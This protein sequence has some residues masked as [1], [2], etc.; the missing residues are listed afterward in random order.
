LAISNLRGVA[1]GGLAGAAALALILSGCSS[2]PAP[3]T[4]ATATDAAAG[5][6]KT[7]T[8]PSQF[9]LG[10]FLP[11]TG[12]L[13][14]LGPAAV[15]GSA[16]AIQ[17]INDAGGVNGKPATVISTDSSDASHDADISQPSIDKLLSSNVSAILGAESSSVTLNVLSSKV[18]PAC[19]IMFSPANTADELSGASKWYFRDAVP[20]SVE[21]DALG[22]Q[23]L[24]DGHTKVAILVFS[25]AYGV[26]LRDSIEKAVTDNGGTVTYGAKGSNQEFA[27]TETNFA[28]IVSAALATNPDAIVV[29]AFDQTPAILGALGSA[30]W[31]M[32]NTYFVDGNAADYTGT[33]GVPD[34]TGA[35]TS[36][37]GNIPSDQFVT[38]ATAAYVANGGKASDIVAWVYGPESYDAVIILALAADLAGSNAPGDIQPYV[39]PVTGS[40]NGKECKTYA[41]C[42]ALI[43]GGTKDI[44]FVGQSGIGPLNDLHDPSTGYVTI[45]SAVGQNLT[46]EVVTAVQGG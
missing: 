19:V 16:L 9:T 10:T 15:A 38:D 29:D 46:A 1:A 21:G 43:K 45:F 39:L 5:S 13:A 14:S 17:E 22:N 4:T 6:C 7:S 20:N 25:D 2:T 28:P 23:I 27:P 41:D 26:N 24:S 44:H 37:Q 35:K 3:T 30:G 33:A 32:A 8:P 12:S 18:D 36:S 42:L 31:T 40:T 11:L 34:L